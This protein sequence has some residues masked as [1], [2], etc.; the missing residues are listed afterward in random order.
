MARS[1]TIG[2]SQLYMEEPQ[3]DGL[4]AIRETLIGH[5]IDPGQFIRNIPL[6][7]LV[8]DM[9][10][11]ELRKEIPGLRALYPQIKETLNITTALAQVKVAD[12]ILEGAEAYGYW[13]QCWR[14][15]TM[16]EP[17]L[18]LP[19]SSSSDLMP[20]FADLK[21]TDGGNKKIE[22]GQVT[23]IS[24]DCSDDNGYY[25]VAAQ[26]KR[27]WIKDN[28]FRALE[29]HLKQLGEAWYWN[30][31]QFQFTKHAAALTGAQTD[32]LN[33]LKGS[34]GTRLQAF[35]NVVES[36]IPTN[37]YMPDTIIMNPTDAYN[38][39]VEQWGTAGPIPLL[40]AQYLDRAG[41]NIS[42]PGIAALIGVKNLFVTPWAT[43]G[44]ALVFNSQKNFIIG[45]RQDLEFEDWN[46]TLKGLVGASTSMRFD[47]QAGFTK[48][49]FKI[50]GL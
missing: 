42:R 46:D 41:D 13:K 16:D 5:S 31:G 48:S 47:Q 38:T 18:N 50:T 45:L 15:E 44:T 35:I 2:R 27:N 24:F 33:N 37:R 8:K 9:E 25:A 1:S 23:A 34:S 7:G 4:K 6:R 12:V 43:Q 22:G 30:V 49:G 10:T 32:T 39:K 19:A 40:S 20:S 14:I 36:K 29:V 3:L 21:F 11:E 26:V 28:N 17:K